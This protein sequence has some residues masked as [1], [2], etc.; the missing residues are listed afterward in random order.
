M[1]EA[2]WLRDPDQ[3]PGFDVIVDELDALLRRS[4]GGVVAGRVLSPPGTARLS[5]I[6]Q[7]LTGYGDAAL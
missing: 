5:G 6:L 3:R 2:C 7:P 1:M 4:Q